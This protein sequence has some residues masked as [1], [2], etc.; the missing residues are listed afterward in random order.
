MSPDLGEMALCKRCLM[1]PNSMVLSGHQSQMIQG[2]PLYG[3]HAVVARL[4]A[5]G[6]LAGMVGPWPGWLCNLVVFNAAGTLVGRAG[7]R[8]GWLCNLAAHDCYGCTGGLGGPQ[9]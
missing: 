6:A 8:H 2:C 1:G 9:R 5:T 7:L 4:T 3:L